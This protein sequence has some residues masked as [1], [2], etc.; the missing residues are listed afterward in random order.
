M[1]SCLIDKISKEYYQIIMESHE[2][3]V[4]SKPWFLVDDIQLRIN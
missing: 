1:M 3:H 2:S 4:L